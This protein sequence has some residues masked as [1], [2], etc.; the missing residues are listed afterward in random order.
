MNRR[1]FLKAVGLTSVSLALGT[2]VGS[3]PVRASEARVAGFQPA[4]DA[5]KMA[6]TQTPHGV[7]TNRKPN[8]LVIMSDEHNAGVLGCNGNR[9]IQTPNLDKLAAAGTTFESCYCNSPSCVPSRLAFTAGKYVSR[10][11]AWNNACWLPSDEYPS[12][13]RIMNAAGVAG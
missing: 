12:L 1:D 6:A 5:A 9:I 3:V 8:I 2:S 11:G 4:E 7:T 10:V 13:P